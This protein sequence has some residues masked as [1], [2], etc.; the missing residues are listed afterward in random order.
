MNATIDKGWH[1]YASDLNPDIGPI[2]TTLKLKENGSFEKVGSFVSVAPKEEFE[3]VWNS[4]V[5]FFENKA[6]LIQKIKI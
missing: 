2:P 6:A 4:K 1:M 5:R 3:E